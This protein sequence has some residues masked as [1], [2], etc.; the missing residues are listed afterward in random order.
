M[1]V[2]HI[3][4]GRE[5]RGGQRQVLLLVQ[6]L[7]G[8]GHECVLLSRRRSPLQHE[9]VRLHINLQDTTLANVWSFS[10]KVDLVHAHDAHAHTLAASAARAPFVV[11]RRVAFPVQSS[12]ASRWKY[13]R[14]TRFL[15]VSQFVA[16][17]LYSAGIP[18]EKVDVVYDAVDEP[19]YQNEWSSTAPAIAL[20]STDPMKGRDLIEAASKEANIDVVFSDDLSHD[21]QHASM[22]LYITRS[23]GFGSAALLAMAMG[24][25]VVA[26]RIGGL[27]E[28][29]KHGASGMY[30]ENDPH[31]IARTMQKIAG[32]PPL[33]SGIIREARARA[34]SRFTKQH[35]LNATLQ[36]YSRALGG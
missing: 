9:G 32:D 35:L 8:A 19:R 23:E 21:L 6:A 28:I 16:D 27:K 36:S 12:I 31:E 2:L 30:V 26:S 17:Q 3:D 11:S 33:A 29:F 7:T 13:G 18:K 1:R 15:A 22:F 20:A 14:A 25:P 24:V 34:M 5:M 4:T 10:R